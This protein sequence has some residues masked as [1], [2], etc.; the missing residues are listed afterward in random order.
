MKPILIAVLAAAGLLSL[1]LVARPEGASSAAPD[2]AENGITVVGVG[3][4]D[5]VPDRAELTFSVVTE[6]ATSQDALGANAARTST[7]IAALKAA[8]LSA[9]IRTQ[10]VGVSPSYGENGRKLNDFTAENTIVVKVDADRT[11]RI[12]DL[13]VGSGATGVS[14]PTFDQSDREALYR[15]ALREAVEL[16]RQKAEAIGA[17]GH[18]SIGDV[19]KV[20]EGTIPPEGPVY[21]AAGER[22]ADQKTP[23]EPGRE[24][25]EATVTVTFATS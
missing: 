7:L 24:T 15:K 12:V 25:I 23:I 14:G 17:A 20:V 5:A 18:V 19:T 1:A 3:S 22:A 4:V 6:G 21:Y 13:A 11:G 10:H 16:A 2:R 8:G 9:D